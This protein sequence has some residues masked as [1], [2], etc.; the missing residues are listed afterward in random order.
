LSGFPFVNI[1]ESWQKGQSGNEVAFV[2]D[3]LSGTS[4]RQASRCDYFRLTSW[5]FLMRYG[6]VRFK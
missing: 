5:G 3:F 4:Q 1:S 6:G 2:I